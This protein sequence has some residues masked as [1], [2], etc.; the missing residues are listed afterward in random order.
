MA[1]GSEFLGFNRVE[2]V[3]LDHL[4]G[5]FI[6]QVIDQIGRKKNGDAILARLLPCLGEFH[7]A[8]GNIFQA[9]DQAPFLRSI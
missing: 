3:S 2:S 1:E 8:D 7:L 4:A 9:V 6:H 5:G